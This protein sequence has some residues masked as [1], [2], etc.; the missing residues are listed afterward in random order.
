M[1]PFDL[2]GYINDFKALPFFLDYS[3]DDSYDQLNTPNK[4]ITDCIDRHAPLVKTKFI[5]PPAPWIKQLGIAEL[6]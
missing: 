5:R 1:K 6:Q 3:F 2:N 4:L